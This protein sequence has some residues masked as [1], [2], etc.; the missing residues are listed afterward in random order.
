MTGLAW[1]AA[2]FLLGGFLGIAAMAVLVGGE[3]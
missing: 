2:G 3:E 1:F